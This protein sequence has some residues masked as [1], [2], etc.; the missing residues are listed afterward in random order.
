MTRNRLPVISLFS[1]IGGLDIGL[2]QAGFDIAVAVEADPLRAHTIRRNRPKWNVINENILNL[3]AEDILSAAGLKVGE[4]ALVVGGPP[5]QPFSKAALWIRRRGQDDTRSKLL[6]EFRRVVL[7]TRHFAFLMENVPELSGKLGAQ[8]FETFTKKLGQG[9]YTLRWAVLN[10]CEF[11]VPQKRRRLFVVGC[12]KEAGV[13]PSFP[14]PT[15]GPQTGRRYISSGDAI[16]DLDDGEVH[17]DEVPSGRYGRFLKVIPPGRNYIWLCKQ[18]GLQL[19]FAPRTR[20][21]SFLLKL[22]PNMPSWT[23]PASPGPS[24]GPFHW[25]S[26]RLRIAEVKRLQTFPD[27]WKLFGS[28]RAMW[29]Q[30]GDAVPPLLAEKVGR[31]VRRQLFA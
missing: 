25:R 28:K 13:V 10:A 17:P 6:L 16:G 21:W 4:P 29:S 27:S 5:C 30:L 19:P 26:R 20:Y 2:E 24:T 11:G 14:K 18:R 1:G 12:R 8:V 3:D 15:H 9:G 7:K 31:H 22:H 23:I